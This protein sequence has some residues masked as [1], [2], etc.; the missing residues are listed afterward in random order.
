MVCDVG[1]VVVLVGLV[2]AFGF[3]SRLRADYWRYYATFYMRI[4]HK[5]VMR[6]RNLNIYCVKSHFLK[7][8]SVKIPPFRCQ[9]LVNSA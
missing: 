5:V 9:N 7:V 3:G 2:C 8:Y 1:G 4:G 6:S